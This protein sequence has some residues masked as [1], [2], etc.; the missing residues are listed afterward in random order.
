MQY[1][2]CKWNANKLLL[3][4]LYARKGWLIRRRKYVSY[5]TNVRIL[6]LFKPPPGLLIALQL[7]HHVKLVKRYYD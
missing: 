4:L 6:A 3:L 1:H 7:V 5:N 2:V